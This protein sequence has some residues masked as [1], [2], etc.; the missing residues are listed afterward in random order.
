MLFAFVVFA[1]AVWTVV[2]VVAFGGVYW[3]MSSTMFLPVIDIS[4]SFMSS[5]LSP[6]TS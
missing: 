4:L 2:G 3:V 5:C 6:V 1:A